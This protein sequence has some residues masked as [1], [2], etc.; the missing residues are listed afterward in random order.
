M[1]RWCC[2]V[3]L[4]LAACA[5]DTDGTTKTGDT[6]ATDRATTILAL[7]GDAV[8]GDALYQSN[9]AGCHG[10]DG[11]GVSGPDIRGVQAET[12]VAAMLTPPSSMPAFDTLADQEIADIAA[13]VAGLSM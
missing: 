9:C 11:A 7:T 4:G 10:T 8:A 12:S 2:V 6:G 13:F 3:L 5:G 1:S